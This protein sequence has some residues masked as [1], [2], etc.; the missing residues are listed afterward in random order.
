ML[1]DRLPGLLELKLVGRTIARTPLLTVTG[2]LS[3]AIGITLAATTYGIVAGLV[4]GKLDVPEGERI[5]QIRDVDLERGWDRPLDFARYEQRRVT[6]TT[7]TPLAAYSTAQTLVGRPGTQARVISVATLS[8]NGFDALRA[9][10]EAGRLFTA[11]DPLGEASTAIVIR[12]TLAREQFGSTAAAIGRP[13]LANNQLRTVVGVMPDN[14]RFP[15]VSD[16][17]IPAT[18][19]AVAGVQ[20]TAFGRL[21]PGATLATAAAEF[22][23][24]GAR[25]RERAGQQEPQMGYRVS[26][27]ARIAPSTSA[28]VGALWL[29]VAAL[30]LLLMVSAANVANLLLART[31]TR[32]FEF[33]VRAAIGASRSRLVAQIGI[34]A[35]IMTMLGA[36]LGVLGASRALGWFQRAVTDLP[37]W[38]NLS[39]R[40]DI[41][42]FISVAS[43]L[44]T[45]AVA[46]LPARQLARMPLAQAI[47]DEASG[48]RFGRF[49]SVLIAAEFAVAIAF[50]GT[51]GS[52]GR[53]LASFGFGE[54]GIPAEQVLVAQVY[55][56]QPPALARRDAPT[57]LAARRAIASA[58]YNDADREARQLVERLTTTAGVAAV[59]RGSHFPGN[60]QAE[61]TFEIEGDPAIHRTRAVEVD[62]G[63]FEVLDAD[64]LHGRAFTTT[65]VETRGPVTVVNVRFAERYGL[66]GAVG[67]RI[68]FVDSNPAG[69]P[70][71][72]P[73]LDIVGVAP[74]LALNPGNAF[75]GDGMYVPLEPMNVVRFAIRSTGAPQAL[76]SVLFT[77]ALALP[78]Q[79]TVQWSK[80]LATQM[81]EPVTLFR[82]LGI[83]LLGLG[84]IA[85]LLSGASIYA[86]LSLRVTRQRREIAVR[87]ALGA[88]RAAVARSVLGR[89]LRDVGLGAAAG[90]LVAMMIS[91]AIASIPYEIGT[92]DVGSVGT[93]ILVLL[94]IG[95]AACAIPLRRAL[96]LRPMALLREN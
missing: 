58:F 61:R 62:A 73:W 51:I 30:V 55:F 32:G 87:V 67:R 49:S 65:E 57:D 22:E 7:V 64:L 72:G 15:H 16:A 80:T 82:S 95:A 3:L 78:T 63:Y 13:L 91:R 26:P 88:T 21:T 92:S 27:F 44:A 81:A 85:L 77:E 40:W 93:T 37:Y 14:F 12:A 5:V 42:A 11:A 94:V 35:F 43:A 79:P 46:V 45:L 59:T 70:R 47:R 52:A 50:L 29:S 24:I 39:L 9:R 31:A 75:A 68:R 53:G 60:E 84:A 96:R 17:W 83:G 69:E 1:R 34:E 28:V 6:A 36:S 41:I 18:G 48:F 76:Q 66:G 10:P 4:F 89:T 86:L 8:Q 25:E 90:L 38:V 54:T 2:V 71:R 20:F 19:S 74:N 23:L 56:G 33:A